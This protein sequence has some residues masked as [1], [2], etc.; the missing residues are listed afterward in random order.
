MTTLQT[1]KGNPL[2]LQI[3]K[4]SFGGIM[5]DE[6]DLR[7]Y[8]KELM[9]EL[10]TLWDSISEVEKESA[11]GIVKGVMAMVNETLRAE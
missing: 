7:G 4:E 6:S 2:Y 9:E 10:S 3:L 1:V 5:Y 8:D 11:G